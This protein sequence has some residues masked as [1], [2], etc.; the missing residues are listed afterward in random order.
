MKSVKVI[1]MTV[2]AT[3]ILGSAAAQTLDDAVAKYTAA[4]EKVQAKNL[5]DAIPL[6]NEAMQLGIDLGDEGAE[7]VREVQGLLPKLNL[8]TA[9][10]SAQAKNFDEAVAGFLK[11]EELA[12]LYGDA[13]TRAQASRAISNVYMMMGVESFNNKDFAKALDVFSK[14]YA[15]DPKNV[16]LATY[17]AKAY[18]ELGEINKALDIYKGII[19]AGASNSRYAEDA[20]SATADAVQYTLVAI[21]EAGKSNDLDKVVALTDTLATVVP[22]E[23]LSSLMVIQLA[24]NL[25]KYDVVIARGDAAATAQVDEDKKADVYFMLGAAYQSKENKAKA[26]EAFRKVTAGANAAAARTAVAD[27]SK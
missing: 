27:L 16:K 11:A 20:K 3:F 4:M 5:K 22:S 14:G 17:T 12:D 7:L 10:M 19:E 9:M 15:Q 21:S 2:A 25:K 23:P 6:L 18:S 24:N 13:T 8:Q 1:L 26:I